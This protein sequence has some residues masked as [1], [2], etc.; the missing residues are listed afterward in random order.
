MKGSP[1]LDSEDIKI[2][3]KESCRIAKEVIPLKSNKGDFYPHLI[4]LDKAQK[5]NSYKTL[6]SINN[7]RTLVQT[8]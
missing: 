3:L 7:L 5:I 4:A 6:N 8:G 2:N 1:R